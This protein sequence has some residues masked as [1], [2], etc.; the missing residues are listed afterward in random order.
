MERLLN[1]LQEFYWENRKFSNDD[2]LLTMTNWVENLSGAYAQTY[3][4]SLKGG[5]IKWLVDNDKIRKD[6]YRPIPLR[7]KA[8]YEDGVVY[9]DKLEDRIIMLLSISDTPI[10]DLISYLK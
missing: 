3:I 6:I 5:F 8:T 9:H 2:W 1:L 4:I 7:I 10:E